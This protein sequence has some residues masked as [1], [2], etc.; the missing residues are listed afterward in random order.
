MKSK[1][2]STKESWN[3]QA[4]PDNYRWGIFYYNKLDKRIFPP[5]QV[6]FLGWTINFANPYA[7]MVLLALFGIIFLIL[8]ADIYLP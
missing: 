4:N 7:Y 2:H 8:I 3:A 5:K 1:T 6:P